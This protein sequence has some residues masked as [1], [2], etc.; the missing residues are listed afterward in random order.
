M[1]RRTEQ[2]TLRGWLAVTMAS[3]LPVG[4]CTAG[5]SSTS[6]STTAVPRL[7]DFDIFNHHRPN[8]VRHNHPH[9]AATSNRAGAGS[10]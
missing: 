8:D 9:G 10:Y 2:P 4:S 3:V 1:N 5:S 7:D 6:S